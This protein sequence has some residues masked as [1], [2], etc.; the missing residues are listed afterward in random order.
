M[1]IPWLA[2][3][4]DGVYDITH[5]ITF[6]RLIALIA[7]AEAAQTFTDMNEGHYADDFDIAIAEAIEAAKATP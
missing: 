1:T 4:R 3:E 2:E 6:A 7:I 5:D